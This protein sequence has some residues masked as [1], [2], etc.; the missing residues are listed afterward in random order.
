MI[1][2]PAKTGSRDL[3]MTF[4]AATPVQWR[5]ILHSRDVDETRGYL[6]QR[7]GEDVRF[8]PAPRQGRRTDKRVEG[9]D[10]SS[11][12]LSATWVAFR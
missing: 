5:R 3:D 11:A 10:P 2:Q 4:E 9:A 7:F 8:D 1:A 12:G 6:H